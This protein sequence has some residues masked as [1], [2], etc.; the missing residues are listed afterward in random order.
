[1]CELNVMKRVFSTQ[2]IHILKGF[3]EKLDLSACT[4]RVEFCSLSRV[5]H[6]R[7]TFV[8]MQMYVKIAFARYRK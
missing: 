1:M 5:S 4:W 6:Q 7:T 8:S 2:N 3:H